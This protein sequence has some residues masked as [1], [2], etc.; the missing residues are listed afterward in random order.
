MKK[1]FKAVSL[2]L[3]VVFAFCSF[4]VAEPAFVYKVSVPKKQGKVIARWKA[5]KDTPF[6]IIH[7]Q[8]VHYS[9]EAQR[10]IP[11]IIQSIAKNFQ[12]SKQDDV[13]LVAVEGAVGE[14]KTD[15]Y[16][17][18]PIYDVRKKV[19]G[20][21]LKK[22]IFSGAEYGAIIS[23]N[24]I[25]LFGVEEQ[26]LF[27]INFN[28]YY[29]VIKNKEEINKVIDEYFSVIQK[30][31]KYIYSSELFAF[32]N[33]QQSLNEN[34][35]D[36]IEQIYNKITES[37]LDITN[38]PVLSML[39]EKA[40]LKK[41]ISEIDT[42]SLLLDI[43]KCILDIKY[44]FAD[45]EESRRLIEY[46]R[47]FQLLKKLSLLEVVP[48]EVKIF[49][50]KSRE[51]N[52]REIYAFLKLYSEKYDLEFNLDKRFNDINKLIEKGTS[53]YVNA[54]TRSKVLLK[55]TLKR[56]KQKGVNRAFLVTGGF[57]TEVIEDE[58]RKQG[59]NYLT[60]M[61]GTSDFQN[62]LP[63]FKKMT[64]NLFPFTQNFISTITGLALFLMQKENRITFWREFTQREIEE[65]ID[66][67]VTADEKK[68]QDGGLIT[69][70]LLSFCADKVNVGIAGPDAVALTIRS[71][72]KTWN[73][74]LENSTQNEQRRR[75]SEELSHNILLERK[76]KESELFLSFRKKLETFYTWQEG[77]KDIVD[78]EFE[79]IPKED[80]LTKA[81]EKRKQALDVLA[82]G[83]IAGA[84]LF[85]LEAAQIY[86]SVNDDFKYTVML[87]LARVLCRANE[88]IKRLKLSSDNVNQV[89]NY[90]AD[91]SKDSPILI[92]GV[93]GYIG[94]NLLGF[95][96]A[97]GYTNI[98]GISRERSV[99]SGSCS[100]LPT[101]LAA[102]AG[103]YEQ[104][105]FDINDTALLKE[106][107][108]KYEFR[109]VVN[110]AGYS[111]VSF[112][113]ANPQP[114]IETTLG[115]GFLSLLG[116]CKMYN[117]NYV[118]LS[119]CLVYDASV[120]NA[121][122]FNEMS[123][124]DP[125]ASLYSEVKR[126]MELLPELYE[127]VTTTTLRLA[128]VYGKNDKA[129]RVVP[130][131]IKKIFAGKKIFVSNAIRDFIHMNDVERAIEHALRLKPKGIFNVGSGKGTS[132]KNL[133]QEIARILGKDEHF[134]PDVGECT[135]KV[136]ID[137]RLFTAKTGWKPE[138]L[139]ETGLKSEI[140]RVLRLDMAEEHFDIAR[141]VFSTFSKIEYLQALDKVRECEKNSAYVLGQ[142]IS[143][144][145]TE[146]V[147]MLP[148]FK[149]IQLY[150]E[151]LGLEVEDYDPDK[152][153]DKD[154]DILI[155][156]AESAGKL[157]AALSKKHNED[158]DL[159]IVILSSD[160]EAVFMEILPKIAAIILW[161]NGDADI[162]PE[163]LFKKIVGNKNNLM[164]EVVIDGKMAEMFL[165]EDHERFLEEK[166]M[167]AA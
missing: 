50:E 157:R 156:L 145:I 48:D 134:V 141:K 74:I 118:Q 18:F 104:F 110:A 86:F 6:T 153:Y 109:H 19:A 140:K 22:G 159:I 166:F 39:F 62:D 70:K 127:D 13:I 17:S 99:F 27:S 148:V 137:S 57:H 55:N 9:F 131:F 69:Q 59:I 93:N 132:I 15:I 23:E 96:L 108:E 37:N 102:K 139:L 72:R 36:V 152:V 136:V 45:N 167:I 97:Q 87:E 80:S 5:K 114:F 135:E 35:Y 111:E 120:L 32:D 105:Y 116:L 119:T 42:N 54:D 89:N 71:I 83:D 165:S 85:Y 41:D 1:Y 16:R 142:K 49:R 65:T 81:V 84:V 128:N 75:I 30:L 21:Y 14:V 43:N 88:E 38:Y 94:R 64:G 58:C 68:L 11:D 53:F 107:F 4:A 160:N 155:T 149:E 95:L 10:N 31:K 147:K 90:N 163:R 40:D 100:V 2:I 33:N 60:I 144:V 29:S 7:I 26:K 78:D 122:L 164:K 12:F 101:E 56:M 28:Q 112:I 51:I 24:N 151:K 76:E 129:K 162:K 44:S 158:R 61:S 161:L 125:T 138:V 98:K 103:C 67:I 66:L 47:Y 117:A 77:E 150:F 154:K 52:V 25:E 106:I 82:Q 91:F 63:H 34:S 146:E 115:D 124:I 143:L 92:I 121:T 130:I 123:G 20:D 8:D 133:A 3:T 73:D 126:V 113:N 79:V 46:E